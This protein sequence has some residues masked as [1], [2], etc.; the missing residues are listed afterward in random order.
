MMH[1]T[2]HLRIIYAFRMFSSKVD[3]GTLED[4][5]ATPVGRVGV[6]QPIRA[7]AIAKVRQQRH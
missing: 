7:R 4:N 1:Q 3:D 6:A 2:Y 5:T